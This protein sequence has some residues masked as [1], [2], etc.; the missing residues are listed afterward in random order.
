MTGKLRRIT[1]GVAAILVLATAAAAE[2]LGLEPASGVLLLRNGQAIEGKI[3]KA[4]EIYYIALPNGQIRVRAGDVELYC[5]TLEDGYRQKR[6][7]IRAGSVHDHLRLARWC[8]RHELFGRAAGELADAM[9]A[10]PRHP[11]IDLL[12]RQLKT[13][14]E[15]PKKPS[16]PRQPAVAIVSP[17]DLDRLVRGMPAG[18][19]ETFT[20][21]IQP[22]LV[23]N[24]T[25]AGCHGPG[26]KTDFHLQRIP[27]GGP[28]SRRTT[29]R[30]L[31]ATLQWIDRSDPAASRL[32]TAAIR[33]HGTTNTPVFTSPQ[34]TQFKW[35]VDWVQRVAAGEK[36]RTPVMADPHV[37]PAV[38]TEPAETP[39]AETP[40]AGA[41]P[42]Q[43]S[44]E[45]PPLT[46][47]D[48]E[49]QPLMQPSAA[50]RGAPPPR[51]VPVDAFD[52]EIFN[53]RY[54]PDPSA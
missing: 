35:L 15:P 46:E 1:T 47:S 39:D 45:Q 48:G 11:M 28:P 42:P 37:R 44:T 54:F 34:V 43:A 32:L 21:K 40:D 25:T 10:D 7:A 27:V 49:Q 14:M 20:Q 6:A 8:L 23:N 53:R 38:Y 19:V 36:P 12:G 17:E 13:A 41:L 33:P 18:T 16:Q 29:Q 51:F 9:D 2:P 26:T 3:S 22:V 50:K 30:N 4:G 5:R 52:P 31:H 24:C